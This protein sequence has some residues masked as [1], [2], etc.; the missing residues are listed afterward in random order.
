MA[1]DRNVRA[2]R[3]ARLEALDREASGFRDRINTAQTLPRMFAAISAARDFVSGLDEGDP[4][5]PFG[6]N[7][8]ADVLHLAAV[9]DRADAFL[10]ALRGGPIAIA[11]VAERIGVP[12]DSVKLACYYLSKLGIVERVKSGRSFSVRLLKDQIDGV[13][14]G[15]VMLSIQQ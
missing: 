12:I 5:L 15:E 4:G 10:A 9:G 6:D 7:G 1:T 13:R 8:T 3:R 2:Q 14:V 11:E